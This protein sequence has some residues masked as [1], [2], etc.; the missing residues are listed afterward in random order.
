MQQARVDG[1]ARENFI[2]QLEIGAT[3]K[4][5]LIIASEANL[6]ILQSMAS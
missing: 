4:T 1:G 2:E 6:V 5:V 3:I